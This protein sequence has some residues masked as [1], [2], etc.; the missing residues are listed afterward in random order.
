MS[1]LGSTRRRRMVVTIAT[2]VL[3]TTVAAGCGGGDEAQDPAEEIAE[4]TGVESV[5]IDPD[6]GDVVVGDGQDGLVVTTKVGRARNCEL[7]ARQLD[8]VEAWTAM[9]RR[10]LEGRLDRL[11]ELLERTKESD[12]G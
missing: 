7:A 5:D 8:E 6:T 9:Y 10:M 4:K 3:V 11:G 12:D 2:A 1:T